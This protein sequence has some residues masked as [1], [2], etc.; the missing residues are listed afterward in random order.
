M[1]D[2]DRFWSVNSWTFLAVRDFFDAQLTDVRAP[3]IKKAIAKDIESG[4][5]FLDFRDLSKLEQIELCAAIGKLID[6]A[7]R[8]GPEKWGS[9]GDMTDLRGSFDLLKGA[10][11]CAPS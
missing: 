5:R 1:F 6:E 8:T 2:G 7:E 3:K 9:L 11:E 10:A 4:Q